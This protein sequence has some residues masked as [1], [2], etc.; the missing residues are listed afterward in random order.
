MKTSLCKP[1]TLRVRPAH[2]GIDRRLA[3]QHPRRRFLHLAAG[4]AA[5]PAVSRIA[6]AQSYPTRPVRIIVGFT[7]GGPTDALAR[8]MGQW[9]SDRLGQQFIIENRPGAGTNIATEAV[10]HAPADGHTL[11]I[12][13]TTAAINATLY[14]KLNFVF[15]RDITP[16]AGIIR[17]PLVMV[18]HPS[19]P[20]K[21]VPEFIAYAKANP[22]IINFASAG[23]GTSDH[24]SGELFKAITGVNMVHVPYRGAAPAICRAVDPS[25]KTRRR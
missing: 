14:E 16:V 13:S 4:A 8:L 22:R 24:V 17:A 5:L 6:R 2:G 25:R 23:V 9:L 3:G 20:A 7:P 11:L 12:V 10:V 15:L 1:A 21:S 19:V 18:V